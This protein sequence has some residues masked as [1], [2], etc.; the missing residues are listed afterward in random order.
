MSRPYSATSNTREYPSSLVD[1]L[2]D[3]VFNGVFKNGHGG[4][5]REDDV[6]VVA[7]RAS[8]SQPAADGGDGPAGSAERGDGKVKVE[9]S[10]CQTV[11]VSLTCW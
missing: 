9:A 8:D 10:L 4:W 3:Q 5:W 11:I 2:K 7:R 6:V 1:A